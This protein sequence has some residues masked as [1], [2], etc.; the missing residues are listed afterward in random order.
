MA[1]G[2]TAP[3]CSDTGRLS[4]LGPGPWA[5][6]CAC[7]GGCACPCARGECPLGRGA[8]PDPRRA[9]TCLCD[10]YPG[11]MGGRTAEGSTPARAAPCLVGGSSMC[12][13]P[14][15][16]N[17]PI[18]NSIPGLIEPRGG[19]RDRTARSA[20]CSPWQRNQRRR[21][22]SSLLTALARASAGPS[23]PLH[24]KG[25]SSTRL[26]AC[27]AAVHKASR[28]W[29][30]RG[31]SGAYRT[32][33]SH[34]RASPVHS[35]CGMPAIHAARWAACSRQGAEAHSRWGMLALVLEAAAVVMVS[36][37]S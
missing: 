35:H 22:A 2:T 18:V 12:V 27:W 14:M 33:A 13:A 31:G 4:A 21:S 34:C 10:P 20:T 36:A 3:G 29:P 17:R 24:S 5:C 8:C 25:T 1:P 9:P 23:G 6:A 7:T 19:R 11:D 26:T 16:E 30:R 28:C 32:G 37:I 15:G